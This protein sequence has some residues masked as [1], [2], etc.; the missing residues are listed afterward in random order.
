MVTSKH[1]SMI[2]AK[3]KA[4]MKAEERKRIAYEMRLRGHRMQDIAK[5][6][7]VGAEYVSKMIRLGLEESKEL[8]KELSQR[9]REVDLESLQQLQ[10][11][12]YDKAMNG[13]IDAFYALMKIFE[14]RAKLMGLDEPEKLEVEN[15]CKAYVNLDTSPWPKKPAE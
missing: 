14:R 6:I 11:I 4:S 8:N 1:P 3:R 7:G 15:I 2:A 5:A 13:E 9:I 10:P 12:Y